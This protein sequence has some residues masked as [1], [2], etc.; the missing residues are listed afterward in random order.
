[1]AWPGESGQGPARENNADA[2]DQNRFVNVSY[3]IFTDMGPGSDVKSTKLISEMS[4][5]D[6]NLL[7][8]MTNNK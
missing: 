8:V 6:L 4:L 7:G 5:N 2:C 1:M 3:K